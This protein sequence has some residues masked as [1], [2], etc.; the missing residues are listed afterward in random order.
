[1]KDAKGYGSNPRGAHSAGI[2][3][4]GRAWYHGSPTGQPRPAGRAS[5]IRLHTN[6]GSVRVLQITRA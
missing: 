6:I 5:N 4:V 2:D 1:M 3:Q